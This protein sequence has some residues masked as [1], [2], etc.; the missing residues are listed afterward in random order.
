MKACSVDYEGQRELPYCLKVV[1]WR[2]TQEMD[3]KHGIL[4][5]LSFICMGLYRSLS[6]TESQAPVS[7]YILKGRTDSLQDRQRFIHSFDISVFEC[8]FMCVCVCLQAP[9]SQ[10]RFSSH[11]TRPAAT[12]SFLTRPGAP[13]S[14]RL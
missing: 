3:A 11:L 8:G 14:R 12:H 10:Y 1:R 13:I 2:D 9:S 5:S 4:R 6:S 7:H